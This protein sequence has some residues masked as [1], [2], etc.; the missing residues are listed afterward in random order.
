MSQIAGGFSVFARLP[1][2]AAR[3][4]CGQHHVG[5]HRLQCARNIR[6]WSACSKAMH[7]KSPKLRRSFV[8][9][10]HKLEQA[11]ATV[12]AQPL[13]KTVSWDVE[14][15]EIV[16]RFPEDSSKARHF[17]Y[18]WLRDNCMCPECAHPHTKQR[19]INTF[20]IPGDIS[21]SSVEPSDK[22]LQIRWSNDSHQSL[23]SWKWLRQ[24]SPIDHHVPSSRTWKHVKPSTDPTTYPTTSYEAISHSTSGLAQW[25]SQIRIYG[26]AF[27]PGVPPSPEATE[28]LLN[29]I[30]FI[31]P[32]HYGGFWDF[33]SQPKPTDTAYTNLGLPNHTDSTYFTDPC[34]LQMFH[35]LQPATGGGGESTLVDGFAAAE[36][37]YY[38]D[39]AAYHA[40]ATTP[41]IS[42][43]SGNAKVGSINNT[44]ASSL[45]YPVLNHDP[46]MVS[47]MEKPSPESL[48]QIR[49]NNDDR[50]SRTKWPNLKAMEA[51]YDAARKWSKILTLPEFE[52]ELQLQPGTPVIF[53]NQ[54]VL[55]G[56]RAF[57]GKRRVCGGYIGMDDFLA[58][59][60]SETRRVG[61]V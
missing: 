24:N 49:W 19:Q 53:D 4:S 3:S 33:T 45:G 22:D 36:Y 15:R 46:S 42:H 47:P 44:A 16:F 51:W 6:R 17:P 21:I 14:E 12:A 29:Q 34:G 7:K 9:H 30:A 43:A 41:I 55:H 57:E 1:G 18:L 13:T 8:S 48:T 35:V 25:L 11:A 58:K 59:L 39:S 60:T 20:E 37:L 61:K 26:F 27:V 5:R 56:R 23:Y 50:H 52:I 32:T 38:S 40:L 54:R 28:N 31:R 2:L 10:A